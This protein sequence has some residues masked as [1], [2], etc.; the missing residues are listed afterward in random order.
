MPKVTTIPPRKQ[1]NHAVASQETRKI[2][3][4][5][6]CR[7]STDTEEQATSYQAQIAHYEEVIHR[8]PEWVFAGI[9]ADDGISATSTKHREQFHQMIQDCMDG[10]IDMLITKSISRFARN[11]VDCLNYIRQLKAQNIPIYF[12]KESINTMD[13][14]GEVLITIMASLAQQE[15][16]SLSQNVKLGMQ[17]RFQQGKVMVNASCFLGYDKDENGDLV[18]NP[19]QAETVKRIY[20]EYLEGAS[21]QQ[22]ARG[23]ERDGI[24]TARGNT[25]WHDSSIRLILENEKY[26]GDAL[27]QKTY[28]V[29]FLKKKRIKNNG[30]MP[31]YYVDDNHP[32]IIPKELFLAVQEEMAR[33]GSVEDC[34]GRK[35]SFSANHCF[36]RLIVCGECGDQFNRIHWNNRGKKSIVWRCAT[37][38]RDKNGCHARTINEEGL[39]AAFVEALNR[40]IAEKQEYLLQ[41]KRNI[42]SVLTGGN[43][44]STAEIDAKLADLE[45]QLVAKA[46]EHEDY[47]D[48][49]SEIYALRKQRDKLTM[50]E[51]ARN[52]YLKRIEELESFID[53]QPTKINNFEESLV[54]RMLK[55]A[56]VYEDRIIFEFHSGVNVE[57]N[58]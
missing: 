10:K 12:E 2:R 20:R 53:E 57:V 36:T 8:N 13:A 23:L 55:R 34:K 15:S 38:L 33:R 54:K 48:I 58:M 31:Q 39:K 4:A 9:Y 27:L 45:R 21:C 42:E 37:R 6:Y 11:T 24:R 7:V 26:M 46:E 41:L 51:N 35:R 22:I 17:Y 30:E 47:T 29:D 1:R 18:I 44:E 50:S 14:K 32:A 49:A 3:V 56:T 28:T 19:E 25:R 40:I 43:S 5:A 16:E 52:D